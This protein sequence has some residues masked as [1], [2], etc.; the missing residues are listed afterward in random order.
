MANLLVKW[1]LDVKNL[2]KHFTLEMRVKSILH[3]TLRVKSILHTTYLP[4]YLPMQARANSF[5]VR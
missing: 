4:T 2:F 3:T 5:D 1:A